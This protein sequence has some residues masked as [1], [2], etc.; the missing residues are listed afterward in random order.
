MA[1]TTCFGPPRRFDNHWEPRIE[2]AATVLA[3]FQDHWVATDCEFPCERAAAAILFIFDVGLPTWGRV[4]GVTRSELKGRTAEHWYL[5]VS[6]AVFEASQL[7][8]SLSA[9]E[10]EAV[11]AEFT[12]ILMRASILWEKHAQAP[13][14]EAVVRELLGYLTS[15]KHVAL[16][17]G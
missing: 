14:C 4:R 10:H 7:L 17:R 8:P 11:A 12:S 13:A 15:K 1:Q 5:A 6:D 16:R 2:F 3:K 9:A